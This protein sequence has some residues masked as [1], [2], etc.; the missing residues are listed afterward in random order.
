[1]CQSC[2]RI[3][4]EDTVQGGASGQVNQGA[5]DL[6]HLALRL[7]VE[8]HRRRDFFAR[9]GIR[10]LISRKG[11]SKIIA[12]WHDGVEYEMGFAS[13]DATLEV[14]KHTGTS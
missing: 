1:V 10:D 6:L 5:F 8:L 14:K 12:S 9:K 4:R 7:G 11:N 13:V 2:D 3:H